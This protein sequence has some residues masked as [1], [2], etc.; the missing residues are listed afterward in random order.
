MRSKCKCQGKREAGVALW[1]ICHCSPHVISSWGII[2]GFRGVLVRVLV[3][4]HGGNHGDSE[5]DTTMWGG[6]A[7]RVRPLIGLR[8]FPLP[9][10]FIPRQW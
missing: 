9:Q 3:L 7:G 8:A 10:C 6:H 5:G 1:A 4:Q 2:L